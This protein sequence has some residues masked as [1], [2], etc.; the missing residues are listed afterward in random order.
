MTTID[1][2]TYF[3]FS[4][5]SDEEYCK[6]K[7]LKVRELVIVNYKYDKEY[8]REN[9]DLV[10]SLGMFRSVVWIMKVIRWYHLLLQNHI[11]MMI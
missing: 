6:S 4:K 5:I 8:L 2:S 1:L 11:N 9:M 10:D 3:D 7:H